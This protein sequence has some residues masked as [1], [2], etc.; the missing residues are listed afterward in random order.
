MDCTLRKFAEGIKLGG[1]ADT[2]ES[3]AANQLDLDRLES[4]AERNLKKFN[5]GKCGIPHL[6][7]NTPVHQYRL[8]ADL[9]E[10]SS[11]EKDLRILVDNKL[12][13]NVPLWPRRPMVSSGARPVGQERN[14]V[15]ENKK[16]YAIYD[17]RWNMA[18]DPDV[19]IMSL[20]VAASD[21]NV[22][23]MRLKG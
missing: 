23:G 4:W 3:C 10:N 2:P 12:S 17:T 5:K 6:G 13:S 14:A 20:T 1:V 19:C 9:M 18:H 21:A 7:S 16:L 22:W 8:G 15:E 11:T